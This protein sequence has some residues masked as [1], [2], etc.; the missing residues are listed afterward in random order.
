MRGRHYEPHHVLS[1]MVD[2]CADELETLVAEQVGEGEIV[3]TIRK[4]I[5]DIFG[6]KE[7]TSQLLALD[8]VVQERLEVL[9][10]PVFSSQRSDRG[11]A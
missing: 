7:M 3:E 2:L 10:P 8:Q 9:K 6:P 11:N 4:R 5:D 1:Q